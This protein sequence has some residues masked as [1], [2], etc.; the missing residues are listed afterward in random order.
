MNIVK[1][2]VAFEEMQEVD[3]LAPYQQL[4]W[5][6]LFYFL[7]KNFRKQPFQ[8]SALQI[9]NHTGISVESVRKIRAV[10]KKKGYIDFRASKNRRVAPSYTMKI[11]YPTDN[12]TEST[13][14][15]TT[16]NTVVS[17]TE[18]TTDNTTENTTSKK[19]KTKIKD[20]D[21]Y[22]YSG[23]TLDEVAGYVKRNCLKVNP[24]KFF[25]TYNSTG[26]RDKNG[27]PV[28]DWK[29]KARLW[30]M[31]NDNASEEDYLK[32]VGRKTELESD[33]SYN[34][35]WRTR[36]SKYDDLFAQFDD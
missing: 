35:D 27:N 16:D 33:R 30:H 34:E 10:L 7:N 3:P 31:R 8:V 9:S 11:L 29:G 13:V 24:E 28:T 25:D 5:H 32:A 15:N 4:M 19:T 14:V 2:L 36:K 23:P 26:W 1:Q 20:K 21:I 17:T 22:T 12:T 18:S 6:A